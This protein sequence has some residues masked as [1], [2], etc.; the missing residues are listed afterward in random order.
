MTKNLTFSNRI[1]LEKIIFWK[2]QIKG[3]TVVKGK[4]IIFKGELAEA[5]LPQPRPGFNLANGWIYDENRT[6]QTGFS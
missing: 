5:P 2:F 4:W 1:H 6:F 3:L